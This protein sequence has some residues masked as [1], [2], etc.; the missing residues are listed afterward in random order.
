MI[1]PMYDKILVKRND[2]EE[3]KVGSIIIPDASREKPTQG[4]VLSVG[5]G[6]ILANGNLRPLLL[7]KGDKI[8]FSIHS[9]R[10]IKVDGEE[11]LIMREDE[12]LGKEI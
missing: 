9:G 5:N 1:Q 12:V 11:F 2:A 4:T 3:Q 6:R 10:E 8:F 7:K